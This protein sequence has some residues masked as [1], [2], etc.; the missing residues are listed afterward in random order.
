M[1]LAALLSINAESIDLVFLFGLV[2]VGAGGRFGW[3]RFL[4]FRLVV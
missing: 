4:F 1:W 3:F 2:C